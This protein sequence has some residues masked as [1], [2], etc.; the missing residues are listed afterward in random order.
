MKYIAFFDQITLKDIPEFGGKNASLGQMIRELSNQGIMVPNG[1]ATT[2]AAYWY[3]LEANNLMPEMKRIMAE[4]TDKNNLKKL[5][6]VGA[7][8][9]ALIG[10]APLPQDLQDEI[11]AAYQELS[12]KYGSKKVCDVAVRSSATAEDLPNASFAG[13]QE[14]FLNIQGVE[15]L[16]QATVRCMASLFTDRAIV[17]RQ[18][19]GFDDFDVALSV[20]VQKMVRSDKASAGVLFTLDT[21]TGF[22]NIVSISSAYGLGETVVQGAV[23]PD[24]F[25]VHKP[26]LEQG[27]KPIIKK[28]LGS[29]SHKLVYQKIATVTATNQSLEPNPLLIGEG[30]ISA[31]A[32]AV[33]HPDVSLVLKDVSH[34]QQ[35][36]FSLTDEEV[37]QLARYGVI[38]ENYYSKLHGRWSPMDI[39]WAK[40]GVDGKLY[41]VQAR[42]ETVH[43]QKSHDNTITDYTLSQSVPQRSILTR[44]LAIGQAVVT[45]KARVMASLADLDEFT[46]GDIII[47]DMTDPDWV[48]VM[49]RAGAIVTDRGGRTCHAAIVSRELGIPAVIGT[50]KATKTIVDGQEITVDCSQGSQGYVYVGAIPF[51]KIV[52]KLEE[53]PESPVKLL[54]NLADPDGAFKVSFLPVQGVGLARLEFIISSIIKIHPMAIIDSERIATTSVIK[55]IKQLSAGYETPRDFFVDVLAQSIGMI[56]AAFYP[57]PVI[58]RLTDFKSNEYRELLGGVFFE[59]IEEN[60]MLGFRGAVRYCSKE[61]AAAFR[62]ECEAIKKVRETMGLVNVTIMVPFVRTV[63]EAQLVVDILAENGIVR[64]Q[65]GLKLFM[66]VEVPSNVLLIEEFAQY[67]DGFS[68]GSNDLTQL[69]LGVDRDSGLLSQWFDERDPAVGKM[70]TMAIQGAHKASTPIG[71]CGQGPSDFPEFGQFLVKEGIDSISLMPDSVIPFLLQQK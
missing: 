55:Q 37:L 17:Y 18:E 42:P 39:E 26:T 68:I 21:E 53:L 34:S 48:S 69:T 20:G 65:N 57:R 33:R 8:V 2:A 32:E 16:L 63:K 50:G 51:K 11:V 62:L 13:Q 23:N 54:V 59:P 45:G 49:K 40:D 5:Q 61:Y 28:F 36:Q 43:S 19:R 22:K 29:K 66:M 6:N 67:F 47:T 70:L 38:I 52:T 58:V 1:F 60:P 4:L 9:R 30:A 12:G 64:G 44:G 25:F 31:L 41:I 24:E 56:A 15:D 71:I 35:D 27:Y 3:H 10:D 14:T 46:D 7:R